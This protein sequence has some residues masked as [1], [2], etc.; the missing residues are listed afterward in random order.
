MVPKPGQPPIQIFPQL[1]DLFQ[2]TIANVTVYGFL[3][4][5][6]MVFGSALLMILVSIATRPPSE[7]TIKRY[8]AVPQ[9]TPPGASAKTV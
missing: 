3:P 7:A 6:P 5:V 2:R 8:F 1:G 9:A 4:V